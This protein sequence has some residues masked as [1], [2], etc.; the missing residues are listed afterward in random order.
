MERT[1]DIFEFFPNG[2]SIWRC[3]IDGHSVAITRM[4]SLAAHSKNEFRVMHLATKSIVAIANQREQISP[5]DTDKTNGPEDRYTPPG[6]KSAPNVLQ[7][8]F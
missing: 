4:L 3:A 5:S 6:I 1:Y 7:I 2:S 8:S